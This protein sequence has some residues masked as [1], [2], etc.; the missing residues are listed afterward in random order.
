MDVTKAVRESNN[1]VGGRL[2]EFAG[3]EY[4]VRGRGYLRSKADLDTIVLKTDEKGTPVLM[5]DVATV[6]LG[7][8][9]RRGVWDLDARGDVVSGIVV[10]RHGENARDVIRR[11]K[12]RL[13]EIEPS[14]PKGVRIVTT[15]DRSE[16]IQRSIDTLKHELLLE[17]IIVSLV[18]LV[19]LWHIPSAIVPIVT[20]PCRCSWRSSPAPGD[21]L[22]H[23]PSRGSSV[24]VDG[25][26]VRWRTYRLGSGARRSGG[27][28][29]VR[30]E[31]LL[32]LL[33]S[34][35]DRGRLPAH[36]HPGGPEGRSSSSWPDQAWH[37]EAALLALPALRMLFARMDFVRF[38]RLARG[39][40]TRRRWKYYPEEKHPISRVPSR[41]TSRLPMG[42]AQAEPRSRAR[43][44]PR[45]CPPHAARPRV[46]AVAQRGRPPL[47]LDPAAS[48]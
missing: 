10:M 22:E 33:L 35:R 19:F 2:L 9:M 32:G 17:M 7:P 3:K 46:H 31:A 47:C 36:L 27:F 30:L 5:R 37:G 20:I 29:A 34:A 24:L 43:A 25:V 39:S 12:E 44:A 45:P 14:L 1:E 41:S 21:F 42:V 4:M 6:S 38:R 28:H 8:E 23:P 11:V 13:A 16:L 15:Y 18:I 48:P 26:I 40:S